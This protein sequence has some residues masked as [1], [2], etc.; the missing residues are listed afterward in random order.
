MATHSVFLT[1]NFN[2]TSLSSI[3]LPLLFVMHKLVYPYL[4]GIALSSALLLSSCS[5]GS[6]AYVSSTTPNMGGPSQ[7]VR[8]AKIANEPR[9][10]FYYG[11]RYYV[12]NTRFWG[13]LRKPG[14]NAKSSKLVIFN[15][16][17]KLNPDRFPEKGPAEK[18]Y[19]HDQNYEYRIMGYYTGEK[20][21][22]INSNQILPEFMLTNYE[23]VDKKPGWLFSPNDSYTSKSLTLK[24]RF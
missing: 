11:R 23:L 2:K 22:E 12:E 4:F 21:Y 13:Y 6:S 7:E 14:Q 19:G 1:I 9:G 17:K 10:N 24:P 5:T 20:A 16:S 8:A 3:P 18:R 15:E